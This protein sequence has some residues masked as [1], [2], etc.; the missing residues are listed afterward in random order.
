MYF[1]DVRRKKSVLLFVTYDKFICDKIWIIW[2]NVSFLSEFVCPRSD[3]FWAIFDLKGLYLYIYLYIYWDQGHI[4]QIEST[5]QNNPVHL[6]VIYMVRFCMWSIKNI[7]NMFNAFVHRY[8]KY[9]TYSDILY[10][11]DLRKIGLSSNHVF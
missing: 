4:T 2:V 8:E 3:D 6:M 11:L 1:Y 9:I 5:E 7:F 10:R